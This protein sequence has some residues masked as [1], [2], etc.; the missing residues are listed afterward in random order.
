MV[1][2]NTIKYQKYFEPIVNFWVS[3]KIVDGEKLSDVINERHENVKYLPGRKLP[4]NVLAI[5]NLVEACKDATIL[6]FVVP[7]QAIQSEN[8]NLPDYIKF[9]EVLDQLDGKIKPNAIAVSLIKGISKDSD[10]EL[11]LISEEIEE[12]LQIDT[13]VLMGANLAPEVADDK[14]CESTIGI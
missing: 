3:G 13:S 11:K 9:S 2:K 1:G 5:E 10:G 4:L 12:R 14:F 6:I 7:H 8:F